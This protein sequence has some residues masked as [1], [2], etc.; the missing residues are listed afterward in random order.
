MKLLRRLS[1]AV[2]LAA[3]GCESA[4]PPPVEL[5]IPRAL[6]DHRSRTLSDLRYDIRL[7]IPASREEPV[8]GRSLINFRW[9]DPHAYPLVLDFKDP[10]VRVRELRVNGAEVPWDPVDDHVVVKADALREGMNEVDIS[11]VAGDDALNRNEDFLYTLFVPDRT[12]FSLPVFDQPDLKARVSWRLKVPAGWEA[13]A[14]GPSAEHSVLGDVK[15]VDFLESRPI[16]SYLF[17]FAA[18]RF[19]VEEEVVGRYFMRMYHRE[20]DTA[21]VARNRD[22]IFRLHGAALE[23]LE[24]YTQIPYPFQKFEFV[25]IPSFQYGGMEHPGQILYRQAGLMLDESA[26]QSRILGRASVIA[27]ETAHM[28]FGDLVT[29]RWFDDVWAK[30]VFANFMAAKI[31]RPSFPGID[32]DLRFLTAHHPAAYAVDRTA[33]THP[34]RQPLENLRFAGTLYGPII[35]Q[36]APIVMR[37]LER[38]MGEDAFR[39]GLRAYLKRF[40]YGN[41]TWPELVEILDARTPD[42]LKAWSRVWVEEAGRPRIVVERSGDD[43]R[44]RQE[45]PMN[46]G[47]LWPQ[48][49]ELR[50][51]SVERHRVVP[52]ELEGREA[53]AEGVGEVAFILPNGSG[54]EYGGFVLDGE[55]RRYLMAHVPELS[56]ALVRGAAWVTLWEETLDGRVA[57]GAFLDAALDALADERDELVLGRVLDDAGTAYWR[58]LTPEERVS[59]SP[60]MEDVLWRGVSDPDR[61]R[62]ARASFFNAYRNHALTRDAVARLRRIWEGSEEP[63]DL[64]LSEPDRIALAEALALRGVPDAEALLAEQETRIR[65]PDRLARFRFVRPA[66][67]A[68]P[69]VREA[70]FRSLGDPAMREREPWVLA[71]LRYLHHPLRADASLPLVRPALDMLEEIQRTGDIFF[72]GRWLDAVLSGYNT[73]AAEEVVRA[74]LEDHPDLPDRLRRKVLESADLLFRAS[75]IVYG[76]EG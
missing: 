18:G 16:P 23:W 44:V 21:T 20:T 64:P 42:D 45:D 53:V 62:T 24:E 49:L 48:R 60:R 10:E 54:L 63:P 71:G 6:A 26:T 50:V 58:L 55:S 35:Y 75:R 76:D 66:L 7:E 9:S 36:K 29:M 33:G 40:A 67:S 46:R 22:E 4:P 27:H 5:G 69:G 32:H 70:F 41:A 47:R 73:P 38:R 72:P 68:D 43:V 74:Y 34:I 31:V 51:G 11:Y 37:H 14:N 39:D 3:Y 25:L 1:L 17:S 61:P 8:T 19:S 2:V 56:P 15:T 12:H 65:N 28:W 59:L 57:P 52:V 30:E 13:V